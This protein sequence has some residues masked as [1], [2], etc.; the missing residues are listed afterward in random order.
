MCGGFYVYIVKSKKMKK[1]TELNEFC[2][3]SEVMSQRIHW[4]FGICVN[5]NHAYIKCLH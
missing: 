1:K 2:D 5:Y 4:V 3:Q